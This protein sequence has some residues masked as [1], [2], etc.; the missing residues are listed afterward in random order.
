MSNSKA[1]RF[2]PLPEPLRALR[3]CVIFSLFL[4]PSARAAN[5]LK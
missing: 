1:L 5:P 3:L 4:I 2:S